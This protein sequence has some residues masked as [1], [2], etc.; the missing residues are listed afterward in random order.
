[1]GRESVRLELLKLVYRHDR[2]ER[3]VVTAASALE[4]YVFS[5]EPNNA[6]PVSESQADKPKAK[7][8]QKSENTSILD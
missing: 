3:D 5:S 2:S 4:E 7:K 6:K 8:N 1:M